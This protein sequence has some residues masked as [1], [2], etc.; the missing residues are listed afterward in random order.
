MLLKEAGLVVISMS[1]LL[2]PAGSTA[3]VFA[4]AVGARLSFL[5]DGLD[6]QVSPCCAAD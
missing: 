2:E 4:P 6:R 5:L 1:Q 3:T